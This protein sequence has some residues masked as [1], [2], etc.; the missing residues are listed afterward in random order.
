MFI[1]RNSQSVADTC[2]RSSR[3][4]EISGGTLK[5]Y[6]KRLL[7]GLVGTLTFNYLLRKSNF[8]SNI[9]EKRH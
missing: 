2:P 1:L 4:F 7:E 6:L 9:L 8:Q 5:G 3:N